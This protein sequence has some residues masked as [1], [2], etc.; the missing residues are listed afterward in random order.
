MNRPKWISEKE[1]KLSAMNLTLKSIGLVRRFVYRHCYIEYKKAQ[2]KLLFIAE[3]EK[4]T[5]EGTFHIQ[6][7]NESD[8]DFEVRIF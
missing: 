5:A 1:S 8:L 7:I 6:D 2:L 3:N 4:D